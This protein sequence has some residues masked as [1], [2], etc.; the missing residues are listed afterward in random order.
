MSALIV[1]TSSWVSYFA[2][3]IGSAID[4]A[5]AEGRVFLPGLVASELCSGRMTARERAELESFLGELPLCATDLAHWVRVGQFRARLRSEGVSISTP[6][7]HIAQCALDLGAE[8]L[9]EDS[10]FKKIAPK[11][12]LKLL[13]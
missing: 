5:L 1:D 10:I 11:T 9:T 6:D 2:R 13:A 7:A 8:L 12:K 4:E 3:G